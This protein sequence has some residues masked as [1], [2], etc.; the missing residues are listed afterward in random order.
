MLGSLLL[1]GKVL[2]F[3]SEEF[4]NSL[5]DKE[6]EVLMDLLKLN[7]VL[8]FNEKGM[9]QIFTTEDGLKF[10]DMGDELIRSL[11]RKELISL[12]DSEAWEVREFRLSLDG[13]KI[14]KNL[15]KDSR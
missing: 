12:I 4:I 1:K 7:A 14:A 13:Q 6:K 2:M 5:S 3:D 8:S 10:I 11:E 15:V 9:V